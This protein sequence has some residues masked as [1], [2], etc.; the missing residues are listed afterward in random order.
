MRSEGM[1]WEYYFI[2]HKVVGLVEAGY[3]FSALFFTYFPLSSP[4]FSEIIIKCVEGLY[5]L[6]ETLAA[7][8]IRRPWSKVDP[9]R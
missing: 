5:F 1:F 2:F 6:L 4:L 9:K 3:V 7:R 8:D